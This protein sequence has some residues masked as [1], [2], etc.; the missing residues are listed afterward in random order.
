MGF[1][2]VL[3]DKDIYYLIFLDRCYVN[4]TTFEKRENKFYE[5]ENENIKKLMNYFEEIAYS[6]KY[7]RKILDFKASLLTFDVPKEAKDKLG[8][9]F[10]THFIRDYDL[11]FLYQDIYAKHFIPN[12]K[13]IE[14]GGK[15]FF[16]RPKLFPFYISRLDVII[17]ENYDIYYKSKKITPQD[18]YELE[19]EY[20]KS[21][22]P[23]LNKK[24][25]IYD[26]LMNDLKKRYYKTKNIIKKMNLWDYNLD[27]HIEFFN[28]AGDV[29]F[30]EWIHFE[31][32]DLYPCSLKIYGLDMEV[33][34][35]LWRLIDAY[36][37]RAVT[38]KLDV[39]SEV[40]TDLQK[41]FRI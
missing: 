13:V 14:S 34:Y 29:I 26:A 28:I 36:G 37:L 16:I 18:V 22:I 39:W 5:V 17:D 32:Y 3:Q 9:R 20:K 12:W 41:S 23:K 19:E 33:N 38:A 4:I 10:C 35:I 25:K 8:E 40:K 15:D 2:F 7:S 11:R 30:E 27:A 21:L 1:S 6:K 31:H 24:S